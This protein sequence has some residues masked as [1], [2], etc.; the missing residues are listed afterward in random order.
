MGL[1]I[2]DRDEARRLL[3]DYLNH[4]SQRV[5]QAAIRALG[6]LGDPKSIATLTKF[7]GLDEGD[8][9][10][11]AATSAISKLRAKKPASQNVRQLRDEVSKLQ[12]ANDRLEEKIDDLVKRFDAVNKSK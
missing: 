11:S 4:P 8:S 7:T 12:R 1:Q 2:E 3:T 6:E 5:K 10:K 9:L